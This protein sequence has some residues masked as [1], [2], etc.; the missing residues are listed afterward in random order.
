MLRTNWKMSYRKLNADML[1]RLK[2]HLNLQFAIE[3]LCSFVQSRIFR[4]QA[5]NPRSEL[6]EIANLLSDEASIIKKSRSWD[7]SDSR[8]GIS[9]KSRKVLSL[10]E[11]KNGRK[12]FSFVVEKFFRVFRLLM[13]V[14]SEYRAK[15]TE[16]ALESR[17]KIT[18]SGNNL[19]LSN[20]V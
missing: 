4:L 13:Q 10:K 18:C 1:I 16:S 7:N 8:W 9:C 19:F 6:H 20:I 15:F 3:Q 2:E 12:F 11:T 14:A 17:W 5:P